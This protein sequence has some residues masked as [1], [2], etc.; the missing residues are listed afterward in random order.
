[1]PRKAAAR[2]PAGSELATVFELMMQQLML[3]GHT[4]PDS[5][6]SLT[7]QQLKVLFTLDFLGGPTPMSRLSTE[8]GVTPGTL[9]KVAA[10][11]VRM[12]YLERRRSTDDDRVVNVSLA[13]EGR[14]VVVKIKQY[15]R[16]FFAEICDGLTPSACRKLIESHRHIY[17]TY[18]HILG[19]KKRR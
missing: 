8:L 13:E 14:R 7:P 9:T 12:G 6:I 19:E 2:R 1:M 4:L 15:R 16:A 10:G 3:L 5:A 17:E 18:R 11:L